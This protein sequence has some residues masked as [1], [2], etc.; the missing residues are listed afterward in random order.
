VFT[1]EQVHGWLAVE[2]VKSHRELLSSSLSDPRVSITK[3]G[4]TMACRYR[5]GAL[6]AVVSLTVDV[7]MAEPN[8]VA[9][10]V[11]GVRAGSLPLPLGRI[12]EEVSQA[13]NRLEWEVRWRQAQSDPV[14]LIS[15]PPPR[16]RG[17]KVVRIDAVELGE[18][19]IRVAGTSQSP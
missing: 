7:Y 19:E 1:A 9:L 17:D 14:A 3:D 6:D 4:V 18:G 13:T 16:N 10:R 8:V 11:R 5:S 2:L 12:L 15:I